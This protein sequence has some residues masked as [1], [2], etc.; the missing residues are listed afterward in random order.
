MFRAQCKNDVR[1]TESNVMMMMIRIS[2]DENDQVE[3]KSKLTRWKGINDIEQYND[4]LSAN[5]L[6]LS[7][8]WTYN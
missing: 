4:Q 5:I 8:E 3:E 1:W 6:E 7:S 2:K